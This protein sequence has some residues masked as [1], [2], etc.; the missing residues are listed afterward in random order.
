MVRKLKEEGFTD[1]ELKALTDGEGDVDYIKLNKLAID[2]ADAIVQ[3]V[4]DVATELIEYAKA[5][6][7][8]FLAYAED[9]ANPA[10]YK[11]FYSS[12]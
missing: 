1:D 2:Y 6:R 12:L 3:S 10:A 5:S 4:P 9:R 7:K 8:P 11:E